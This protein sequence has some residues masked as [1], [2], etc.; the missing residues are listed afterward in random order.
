MILLYLIVLVEI[1]KMSLSYMENYLGGD[2]LK[3]RISNFKDLQEALVGV[4]QYKGEWETIKI[5]DIKKLHSLFKECKEEDRYFKIYIVLLKVQELLVNQ[6]GWEVGIQIYNTF[7]RERMQKN[8]DNNWEI[9]RLDIVE[10]IL[11]ALFH[12]KQDMEFDKVLCDVLKSIFFNKMDELES[13]LFAG[14]GIQIEE[15]K[16]IILNIQWEDTLSIII[17]LLNEISIKGDKEEIIKLVF[18]VLNLQDSM[19]TYLEL[20]EDDVEFN[21]QIIN[22]VID[23]NKVKI[24]PAILTYYKIRSLY[25]HN[26]VKEEDK[27]EQNL[28]IT[29]TFLALINDIKFEDYK[30]IG[31]ENFNSII[32]G[33]LCNE[34][35][36][37]DFDKILIHLNEIR[38]QKDIP[39]F[40][41]ESIE[42]VIFKP[43]YITTFYKNKM[44]ADVVKVYLIHIEDECIENYY[45]KIAYSLNKCNDVKEAKNIYEK[46][47]LK[48]PT[49]A[50]YNNLGAIYEDEKDLEKAKEYYAE[51]LKIDK[52]EELYNRNF[53]RIETKI[54]DKKERIKN[55]K[56]VYFKKTESYEKSIV[57]SIYKLAIS[58]PKVTIN[59]L[60][61]VL[62][63]TE[64]YIKARVEK[65][66][67][68]ELLFEKNGELYIEN[69]INELVGNHI[70]PIVER[71]VI[72]VNNSKLYRP[73]FYHESE[74]VM[75][76]VL[77]ELFPQQFVFPNL[78]LKTIFEIEKIKDIISK[79]QLEYLY[80]A[81]VDFAI[82]NTTTYFPILAF[83]KD[84]EYNDDEYSKRL[85]ERKNEI[86]RI[87]GIP[88]IRIRF[89]SAIDYEKLKHEI[90]EAT[91]AIILEQRTEDTINNID[92]SKEF[93]V[94]RFG[95][96]NSPIDIEIVRREWEKI[97]G[98]AIAQ[99]THVVDIEEEVLKVEV[100]KEIESIILLGQA[101]IKEKIIEQIKVIK[102]IEYTTY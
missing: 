100:A 84:S 16:R 81:H 38:N 4:S 19:A 2:I 36:E 73:I 66:C 74:L 96:T 77:K 41:R 5:E 12:V 50:V 42:S 94:R 67:R 21:F 85:L 54:K 28:G 43:S 26:I 52:E 23:I 11:Q 51:A 47:L 61:R 78:S 93:D 88:L 17:K 22:R 10:V 68:L 27:I 3:N 34:F 14:V 59:T 55:L 53:D 101:G 40:K 86:F 46:L 82:I 7:F 69:T 56:D 20:E 24:F 97:V 31:K 25:H 15:N 32:S 64:R 39:K 79:E 48:E 98:E 87:G 60:C 70:D 35:F 45:F 95:I 65:L 102:D 30:I 83:E 89:N 76:R 80:K 90:K 75:Y 29:T 58:E 72:K 18:K 37:D 1:Q 92:F 6:K 99:K 9:E 49:S 13:I 63:K 44:Y 91:K 57:F 71:Q 8:L 62:N 33:F